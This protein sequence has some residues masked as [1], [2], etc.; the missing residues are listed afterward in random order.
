MIRCHF[1]L[2]DSFRFD[3][4]CP[5]PRTGPQSHGTGSQLPSD[6]SINLNPPS[7]P[8]P[9]RHGGGGTGSYPSNSYGSPMTYSSSASVKDPSTNACDFH[10][11]GV[12]TDV[13]TAIQVTENPWNFRHANPCNQFLKFN[14]AHK[15]NSGS[16]S[17]TTSIGGGAGGKMAREKGTLPKS[18]DH[19]CQKEIGIRRE[20][21]KSHQDQDGMMDKKQPL[22][23]EEANQISEEIARKTNVYFWHNFTMYPHSAEFV[24]TITN[25]HWS[26]EDIACAN[27]RNARY[28]QIA[29]V[30]SKSK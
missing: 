19:I 13:I 8:G 21:S 29:V 16:L 25:Y 1:P 10:R 22:H 4:L 11:N 26:R 15:F 24:D 17:E 27:E 12:E 23:Q 30:V 28:V 3:Q 6:T 18:K 20:G 7:S 5:D 2:K 14:Y 9:Y